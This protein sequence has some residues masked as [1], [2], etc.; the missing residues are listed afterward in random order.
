MKSSKHCQYLLQVIHGIFLVLTTLSYQSLL[1]LTQ[2]NISKVTAQTLPLLCAT[3]GKDGIGKDG[4][5]K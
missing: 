5:E 3:P 4:I 2:A 1:L